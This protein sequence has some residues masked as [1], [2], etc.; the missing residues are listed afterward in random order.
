MPHLS[1]LQ[2]SVRA[3]ASIFVLPLFRFL[4]AALQ[5]DAATVHVAVSVAWCPERA[6][7]QRVAALHAVRV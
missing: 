7:G 1:M 3:V 2:L 5:T 4:S 6:A